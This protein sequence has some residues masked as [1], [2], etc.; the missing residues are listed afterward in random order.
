MTWQYIRLAVGRIKQYRDADYA[1]PCDEDGNI[2]YYCGF[3]DDFYRYA[4]KKVIGYEI[5]D[6]VMYCRL[7]GVKVC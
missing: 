4:T 1:E 5:R 3:D 6:K 7:E 2:L